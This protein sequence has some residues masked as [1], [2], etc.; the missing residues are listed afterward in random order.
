MD[1]GRPLYFCPPAALHNS[2]C[3]HCMPLVVAAPTHPSCQLHVHMSHM[4]AS[5]S[6]SLSIWLRFHPRARRDGAP[7]LDITLG[8][9]MRPSQNSSELSIRDSAT[10]LIQCSVSIEERELLYAA[11]ATN[12]GM[13]SQPNGLGSCRLVGQRQRL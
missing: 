13:E 2:A 1:T 6:G 11:I 5:L 4:G 10:E 3:F 8:Q 7:D 12:K 9:D